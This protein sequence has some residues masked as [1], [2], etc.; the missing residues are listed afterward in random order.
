MDKPILSKNPKDGK[1]N[2]FRYGMNEIQGWKKTMEVFSINENNLGNKKNINIFGLFE[3]HSG[4]EISQYLSNYFT[5]ELLKNDNFING[6]YKQ[7]LI[8][9]F[10]NIDIS[11][12]KE[13][14]NNILLAY[15]HQNKKEQ[16][17]KINKIYN[18]IDNIN[19]LNNNDMDELNSFMDI[20]DPNNLEDVLIA[21]FVGSSGIVIL[22]SE[23]TTYIANAGN[24]HCIVIDKNFSIINDK[25]ALE[26]ILYN[27]KEKERIKIA[28]GI[29][30]GKEKDTNSECKEYLY[31][32]GFG[33][34]QY[35]N[36]E[37]IKMEDQEISPVPNI[38][39]ISN[40]NI[41]LLIICSS[42]FFEIWKNINNKYTNKNIEKS[43][44]N[45]F[46][47][48]LKSEQK[49]ISEVIGDYFDEFIP[50]DKE[51]CQNYIDY[52]LSCIIVDFFDNC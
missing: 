30:Y 12:K 4:K 48:E 38:F 19:N 37:L 42:G 27:K 16:K 10:T 18:T 13:E 7:S 31:T 39:E 15:S 21:D 52:N 50:K 32:R 33:N 17:E 6:N 46:V 3:G 23:N 43:I 25:N 1:T 28:R 29:K 35:K 26:Q 44:A 22:I 47:N 14:I 45:F 20:I 40:S 36:N 49:I 5:Q 11:F 41:K 9:T 51:K 34:F 24:S 2:I 8:E